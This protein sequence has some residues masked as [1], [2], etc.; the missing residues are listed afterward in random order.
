MVEY[1]LPLLAKTYPRSSR[2]VS[3]RWLSY[4]FLSDWK[5]RLKY[6]EFWKFSQRVT[7][8]ASASDW[9]LVSRVHWFHWLHLGVV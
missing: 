3:L 9:E 4:S 2:T 6:V 5:R 1:P 8:A 7:A